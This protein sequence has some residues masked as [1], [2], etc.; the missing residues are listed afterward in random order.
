MMDRYGRAGGQRLAPG[1]GCSGRPAAAVAALVVLA[2][3][4]LTLIAWSAAARPAGP[5]P[6]SPGPAGPG[7]AVRSPGPDQPSRA[8]TAPAARTVVSFTWGGGLGDQMGALPVF[9]HYRMH[10]TFYVPSGLVCQPGTGRAAR[11]RRT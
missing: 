8:S 4:V 11:T 2:A 9:Q 5:G 7:P 1:D 3:V 6:A 10:A